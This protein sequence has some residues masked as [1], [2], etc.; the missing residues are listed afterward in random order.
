[1]K[2]SLR[3]YASAAYQRL[4][5][6]GNALVDRFF[7]LLPSRP[8]PAEISGL[9]AFGRKFRR[10]PLIAPA[11]S[12]PGWLTRREQKALYYAGLCLPGPFLEV[13]AWAG[14][15]TTCIA[16]GIS[17]STARKP[18]VSCELNPTA[19]NFRQIDA[20]TVGFFYPPGE[21]VVLGTCSIAEY[22]QNIAPIVE[23][24]N[25]VIG[26][27][28]ATL[29]ERGLAEFVEIREGDFRQSQ[30]S[31]FGFVFADCMHT[32]DEVERNV[33]DLR[34]R[35]A[36]GGVL[37]CHDTTAENERLLRASLEVTASFRVGTIFFAEVA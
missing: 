2:D 7:D 37:A 25:G 13:G 24:P 28:R 15:S 4:Q 16:L 26:T 19:A 20:D 1:M 8:D 35:L 29:R 34:A 22:R 23:S 27:L 14:R 17:R 11:E 18:F 31:G 5:Q 6:A 36:S 30:Q 3:S 9:R 21:A 12:V 33:P 32:T 10:W